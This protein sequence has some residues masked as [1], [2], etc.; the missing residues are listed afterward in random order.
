MASVVGWGPHSLHA[1]PA[2]VL[3]NDVTIDA[4]CPLCGPHERL[5][6][7][8]IDTTLTCETHR[9]NWTADGRPCGLNG[10]LFPRL[11]VS[12]TRPQGP[13]RLWINCPL[14]AVRAQPG[15]VSL[16]PFERSPF[17]PY[18]CQLPSASSD[19]CPIIGHGLLPWNN[20][21]THPILGK[22]LILNQ[23]AN[24]SLLPSFDT[25][26]VDPL[27]LSVFA[28]DTRGAI[29][30]LST[31]LTLCPATCILPLGEPFSP[32]VPICRFP[33]DPNE[34]P[35]SEFELPPIQTPGLSWSVPAIDLF[36]TGPPS[37]CDRL[38]VWSSPQALQRFLHDPTL[39]WSELVASRKIRLDSP[40][41]LQLLENEWLSRL[42]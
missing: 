37:P 25:L 19:G 28:P 14:P 42:F 29:R 41:K 5:Q 22:V 27:R 15:P 11:H 1:C 40:L 16:S 23:M 20:L 17:Q 3:S 33:R 13:R 26:L 9:I 24:F 21:V 31:L 30:Y 32:N 39:T 6:F 36:L 10:T 35:L 8:R 12:E 38:H 18:Q 7:E 34:P 4:W 2:L